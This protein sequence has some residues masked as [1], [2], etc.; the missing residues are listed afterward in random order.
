MFIE[1]LLLKGIIPSNCFVEWCVLVV[2]REEVV[3]SMCKMFITVLFIG[4][5]LLQEGAVRTYCLRDKRYH[6]N[7]PRS[8]YD[9]VND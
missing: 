2:K 4:Q 8:V 5:I 9:F 7:K 1:G 6:G 3:S